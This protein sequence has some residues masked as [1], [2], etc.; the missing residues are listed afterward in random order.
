MFRAV[1]TLVVFVV[2][3]R[4]VAP[5]KAVFEKMR[6]NLKPLISPVDMGGL[7][8]SLSGIILGILLAAADYHVQWEAAL[9]LFLTV[10]PMHIYMV[11]SSRWALVSSALCAVVTVYLS[12]GRLFC[13]ESLLLLL[14]A[15]F[16]LRLARGTGGRNRAVDALMTCFLK[17]PVALFG[18]YFV[19]THAFPF[20]FLLFPALSVGILGAVSDGTRDG[21]PRGLVSIS[22]MAGLVLMTV[23]SLLRVFSLLHFLYL[24]TVPAFV[25]LI[26]RMYTKK[27]QEPDLFRMALALCTFALAV[28]T[29]LGLVGYLF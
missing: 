14:F 9:A 12:Y 16:I 19:C 2:V 7:L 6:T 28:L 3:L 17:G 11:N 10:I 15:Y 1:V 25:I 21:Y 13:L 5:S 8:L 18:A 26:V 27:E 4:V 20:W 24:L 29:G 22:V 23:F